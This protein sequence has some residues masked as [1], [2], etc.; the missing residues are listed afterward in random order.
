M[1]DP[2]EPLSVVREA[3]EAY[4]AA[5]AQPAF[6]W[7][8]ESQE[9]RHEGRPNREVERMDRIYAARTALRA[10]LDAARQR[11]PATEDASQ[12]CVVCGRFVDAS[13]T[14]CPWCGDDRRRRK[15]APATEDEVAALAETLFAALG[16][17]SRY[18][19]DRPTVPYCVAC[20]CGDYA[21]FDPLPDGILSGDA[22]NPA[23]ADLARRLTAA[24]VRVSGYSRAP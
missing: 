6:S 24:G 9:A 16:W 4:L 20:G 7:V 8:I 15:S 17:R 3:A 22:D 12:T 14:H 19:A 2:A 13:W 10:T 18:R 23:W 1:S 5:E 21:T 11:A